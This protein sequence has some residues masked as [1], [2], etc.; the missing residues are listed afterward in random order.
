M[1]EQRA[2][3]PKDQK[4]YGSMS[5]FFSK[6]IDDLTAEDVAALKDQPE[7]QIFE[8]K[9]DLPKSKGDA[10]DPWHREPQ[11]GESRKGPSDYAK[12]GLFA[13]LVAF[14]NS[15][16]GWLVLGLKETEDKPPRVAWPKPIPNCHDLA[17]RL[18]RAAQEWVDPPAPSLRCRGI[19]IGDTAGK[20]VIICRVPRSPLAPHRLRKSRRTQEA[21]KRVGEESKPMS[22]REIQDLTLDR[23]RG[24]MRVE[25][26]FQAAR[27]RYGLLVPEQL[28]Y[29]RLLGF[30]IIAIP[31]ADPLVIDRPYLQKELFERRIIFNGTRLGGQELPMTTIDGSASPR[32]HGVRPI[33]RGG[34]ATWT[35][36]Y[37]AGFLRTEQLY[38][39]LCRV[40]VLES[41][42]VSMV[43]KTTNVGDDERPLGLSLRWILADLANALRI[44][45]RARR[46][47][48]SPDAEYAL[49]I[50]LHYDAHRPGE[51]PVAVASQ[52]RFG[53][54][55]DEQHYRK[56]LGPGPLRLPRYL[57][58]GL[59]TFPTVL[60]MVADDLH[61]AVHRPHQEDLSFEQ[62]AI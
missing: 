18:E 59:E 11:S 50:E 32:V 48:G 33:L 30:Q 31:R 1:P 15:E 35:T 20:G 6:L 42:V 24:Q 57:V 54:L 45:E 22:M 51:Q 26:T 49:E 55:D 37:D 2:E 3:D 53:L 5:G 23:A 13:E 7:G 17:E 12:E 21:Y 60:K 34:Q 29:E 47:A 27:D 58:S 44:V 39:D 25:A 43:V 61:N 28:E 4:A 9:Q 52:Y 36:L 38:E 8:I 19:E 40:E 10:P 46:R 16:G 14:A 62:I 56:L 41:G